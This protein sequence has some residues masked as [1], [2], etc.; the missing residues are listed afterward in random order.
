MKKHFLKAYDEFLKPKTIDPP[1]SFTHAAVHVKLTLSIAFETR[2]VLKKPISSDK[3][4][5][6][7]V[8]ISSPQSLVEALPLSATDA[9]RIVEA[10]Q[11]LSDIL[12]SRDKR[13]LV[14]VGPCSIH[15]PESAREYAEKLL[16]LHHRYSD[17]LEIVMRVYFEKPRTVVGWKGLINDPNMD[18]SFDIDKG[19]RMARSL[20]LD[21]AK[22]GIPAGCEFLDAA[23]GQYYADTVSWGAIGARTTESQVHRE[24]AS[25]LSCPVGFKNGTAGSIRIA[26][27]AM[28]SAG[29]PHA[30][31]SPD[32]EGKIALYQTMGNHDAH[33]IL[34]G[35]LEP[36][37]DAESVERAYQQQLS[38]NMA[39]RIL[40]DCSH[41]N[42]NKDYRRQGLIVDNIVERLPKEIDRIGGLMLESHLLP[43]KQSASLT[44]PQDLVYGQSITDACIGFSE[45]EEL[46][47]KLATAVAGT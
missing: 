3:R 2:F 6:S 12:H 35:G 45:T 23:T 24:I 19:L 34:R 9:H 47:E 25:G 36:N 29:H 40:I 38:K 15:D 5:A 32:P 31:L 13:L 43:G 22:L 44:K 17:A 30:F 37:Y 8:P 41:A 10:R 33:L 1:G 46:L 26:I 20:L 7:I 39:Q 27:D 11:R 18:E 28:E 16:A 21:L 14:V 42:S 4:I